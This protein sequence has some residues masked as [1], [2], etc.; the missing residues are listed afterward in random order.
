MAPADYIIIGGGTAGLVLANRLS[1]DPR[2]TVVVI[3]AGQDDRG[4]S[5]IEDPFVWQQAQNT[6]LDWAYEEAS[7]DG[8]RTLVHHAGRTLGGTSMINGL[9][10]IRPSVVEVDAW[11]RLGA[12]GWSWETLWPYFVDSE[13]FQPPTELQQRSGATYDARFHGGEHGDVRTG[14][15][16][17]MRKPGFF[18]LLSSTWRGL[19][20]PTMRDPNGGHLHGF[21]TRPWTL[22]RRSGTR[23]GAAHAYYT[24]VEERPNLAVL[25]GSASRILWRETD[26]QRQGARQARAVEYVVGG[27]AGVQHTL[28]LSDRGEVIVSAGSL[29]TPLVLEASGIGNP[30]HL[31][32]L[33]I[34]TVVNLP[35]VGENLQEQANVAFILTPSEQRQG[36]TPYA[37]WLTAK[38]V[39]KEDMDNVAR[40]VVAPARHMPA[41]QM[42]TCATS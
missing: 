42:I 28:D 10:Y 11:E 39:F 16:D 2:H 4:D 23:A 34:D 27:E 5:R 38:D 15:H 35:G 41:S 18:Q 7:P 40:Y 14:Y 13:H 33:G 17:D 9:N 21:S 30:A 26:S 24:P 32:E 19:G 8:R 22:D 20:V 1:A 12:T 25:H 3:E 29:R 6:E 37:T 36:S 31:A